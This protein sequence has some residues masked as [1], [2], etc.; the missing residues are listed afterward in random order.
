M[1]KKTVALAVTT[2]LVGSGV[3]IGAMLPAASQQATT[4]RLYERQRKGFEK[5]INVDGKKSIAGDYILES[6]PVY[7][8]GTKT[9]VGRDAATITLIR[10]LGKQDA[11]FRVA[12]T[13]VLPTGKVEVSGLNRASRLAKGA[14]FAVVGGTGAY[15]GATGTLTVRERPKRRT[16]FTFRLNL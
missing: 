1:R 5:F 11:L 12:A 2:A 9:K 16:F 3:L 7:R 10:R 15:E 14:P 6:H 4:I 13:F 8:V